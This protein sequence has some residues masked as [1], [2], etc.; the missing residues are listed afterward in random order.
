RRF[1]EADARLLELFGDQAAIALENAQLDDMAHA[2]LAERR[3]TEAH[4]RAS[5]ARFR[6]LAEAAFEAIVISEGE[7]IREVN[8]A[9]CAL[10][11]YTAEEAVGLTASDIIAPESREVALAHLRAASD[12]PYEALGQR[13]DGGTFPMEVRGRTAV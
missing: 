6:A 8:P 5:E 11:G 3:R 13:R 12:A 1:D 2:E 10:F 4:L 9:F 7:V